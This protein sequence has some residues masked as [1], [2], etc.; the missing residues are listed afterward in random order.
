MFLQGRGPRTEVPG[1]LWQILVRVLPAD[2]REATSADR[3][4]QEDPLKLSVGR[5]GILSGL[6]KC[7][8][9][10]D[11]PQ[12]VQAV[13]SSRDPLPAASTHP[14]AR[15]LHLR[16]H[17]HPFLHLHIM[18][19]S[20]HNSHYPNS[21]NSNQYLTTLVLWRHRSGATSLPFSL[22]LV[23]GTVVEGMVLDG[24]TREVDMEVVWPQCSQAL[25]LTSLMKAIVTTS[26]MATG[27]ILWCRHV[28][29]SRRLQMVWTTDTPTAS[30]MRSLL[31]QP[32]SPMPIQPLP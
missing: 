3:L 31:L 25:L 19:Q 27:P 28:L 15:H 11:K 32:P 24:G 8:I 29:P 6:G 14:R 5:Q 16:H 30:S 20:T 22:S 23:E 17:P 13:A 2:L 4:H 7:L 1:W 26:P 12:A 9:T 18:F 21:L 10:G